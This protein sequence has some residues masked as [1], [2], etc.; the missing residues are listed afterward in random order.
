MGGAAVFVVAGLAFVLWPS[1]SEQLAT[2]TPAAQTGST[3]A[4]NGAQAEAEP[5]QQAAPKPDP[6]AVDHS[7]DAPIET[8]VAKPVEPP[9][10]PGVQTT[11][12]P[13][14]KRAESSIAKLPDV[15]ASPAADKPIVATPIESKSKGHADAPPA[16][17]TANDSGHVLK[18][19]PLDFDPEHLSLSS[20]P[21]AANSNSTAPST[22]SIPAET[23]TEDAPAPKGTDDGKP[24]AAADLLP[25]PAVVQPI[26]VRRGPAINNSPRPLDT[27]QRMAVRVKSLQLAEV[28]L[29]RFAETMSELSSVPITLDP[30]TLELNGISPRAAVSVDAADATLE[31]ILRDAFSG[32][33]LELID[34]DGSAG[35]A[36]PKADERRAVDFD[37]KDLINDADATPIAKLIERFVA[38]TS[39]QSTGGKGTIEV[40]GTTLHIE[41]TLLVRREA[42]IFCERLRLARGLALRSNYPA[43]LLT[44]E[45]PYQKLAPKLNQSAT[46]TFMAWTRLADVVHQWQDLTGLTI[47]VDWTAL[48]DA[49]LAPSSPLACS[50]IDRPWAESLDGILAPLGLSWWAVDG[51]TIQITT[52]D[53]LKNV[54]RVEFYA[55]SKKLLDQHTSADAL[56][57]ALQKDVTDNTAKQNEHGEVRMHLDEPSNGLIVR[58]TPAVHRYL[59]EQLRGAK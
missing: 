2:P 40:K 56:I 16:A 47:L 33:R 1:G 46:F 31:K 18:F 59:S 52:L 39:W 38:P 25:P 37:V 35:I 17:T 8:T 55:V 30:A 26:N 22:G 20:G 27:A 58:A 23:H 19:D 21:A 7:K 34:H 4:V 6:Y 36:I 32:Q 24:P 14:D 29:T 5:D 10:E 9:T 11:Q 51:Q 43:A 49:E 44:G 57:A 13:D 50:T 28:P 3:T 53:A 41:Q 48:A 15:P 12:A 45:S 42:L 54:E